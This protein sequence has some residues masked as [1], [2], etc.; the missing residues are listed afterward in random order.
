MDSASCPLTRAH[1]HGPGV[2]P[3]ITQSRTVLIHKIQR[4]NKVET[5]RKVAKLQPPRTSRG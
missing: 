1:H 4:K 2:T 3:I 5:E